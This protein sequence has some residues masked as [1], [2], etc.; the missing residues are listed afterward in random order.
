MFD[1]AFQSYLL[2]RINSN[3]KK[4]KKCDRKLLM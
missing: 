4:K 2:D 1:G 3:K